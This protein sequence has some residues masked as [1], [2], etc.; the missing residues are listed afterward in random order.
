[1]LVRSGPQQA[2]RRVAFDARV[3][4]AGPGQLVLLCYEQFDLALGSALLAA[5]RRDNAAKSQALT[6]AL[7]ALTAL[8]LGV[9]QEAALAPD[10]RQFYEAA[11]VRL[12][13]NGL[14]FDP[15]ALRALRGD[16]AEIALAMAGTGRGR[17]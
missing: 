1:M 14:A 3:A 9:S 15:E 4:G 5:T 8:Q 16:F 12:L 10:L 11:R 2:Y 7:S 13:D 6:R 17:E